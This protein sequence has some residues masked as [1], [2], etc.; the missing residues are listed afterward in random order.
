[1][2]SVEQLVSDYED[3]KLRESRPSEPSASNRASNLG[4]PCVAYLFFDRVVPANKR[5]PVDARLARRFA[6][7]RAH[8]RMLK[9]DLEDAGYDVQAPSA[10]A[11]T[12]L[13]WREYQI[14]GHMDLVLSKGGPPFVRSEIKSCSPVIFRSLNRPEDLRNYRWYVVQ[15][16]Y[17]QVIAYMILDSTPTYWLI[18]K[19]K[20]S[21]DLKVIVFHLN[22]E[23]YGEA[24][25]LIQKAERVNGYLEEHRKN[26]AFEVPITD[27]IHDPT[28]CCD[29][30]FFAVC[31]PNLRLGAGL[32]ISNDEEI[33]KMLDRRAEL[34]PSADEFEDLDAQVKEYFKDLMAP[35][36]LSRGE[37]SLGLCG[38]WSVKV[39]RNERKGKDGAPATA[40]YAVVFG[41]LPAVRKEGS[42][43]SE[44]Q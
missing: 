12:S 31:G 9:R 23:M 41:K 11:G 25:T 4:H 16:W 43:G 6:E 8:E 40:Y 18:L 17:Y 30:D 35:D 44:P 42:D 2:I 33:A 26:S 37:S 39:T 20:V 22:D 13:R 28:I 15:K 36:L 21:G 7:G 5:K 10:S 34:E 19:D 32:K 14:S 27:K 24:E 38:D 3:M 1:M 29:C